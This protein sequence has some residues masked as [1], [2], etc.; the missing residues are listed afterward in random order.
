MLKLLEVVNKF[1]NDDRLKAN[2]SKSFS[3]TGTSPEEVV[4]NEVTNS[5]EYIWKEFIKDALSKSELSLNIVPEKALPTPEDVR[6]IKTAK[7]KK[8]AHILLDASREE[9]S[10]V[11]T[12]KGIAIDEEMI[13]YIDEAYIVSGGIHYFEVHK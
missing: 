6:N 9:S 10:H 8:K 11:Q 2:I 12:N 3:K 13:E 5:P 7:A 1:K 4:L